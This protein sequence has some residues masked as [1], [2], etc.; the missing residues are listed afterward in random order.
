MSTIQSNPKTLENQTTINDFKQCYEITSTS[1]YVILRWA[2]YHLN[3]EVLEAM[4]ENGYDINSY[5]QN[6][7]TA[8]HNAILKLDLDGTGNCRLKIIKFLIKKGA[9]VNAQESR[10]GYTPLHLAVLDTIDSELSLEHKTIFDTLIKAGA[11][12]DIKAV[13]GYT[14]LDI[15]M[16][17]DD[18]NIGI[19]LKNAS[20]TK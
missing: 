1:D 9:N 20:A 8:L 14:A 15:A 2:L 17:C 5:D 16:V 10:Y 3:F 12:L 7:V 18:K 4:I 13:N 6:K 19:E 11:N